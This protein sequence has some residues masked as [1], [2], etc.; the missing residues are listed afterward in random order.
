MRNASVIA[1]AL[2]LL[3]A[4]QEQRSVRRDVEISVRTPEGAPVSGAEITLEGAR[5]GATDSKG[6]LVTWFEQPASGS[7]AVQVELECPSGYEPRSTAQRI[8]LSDTRG[9][10][11]RPVTP[12][13]SLEC[14]PSQVSVAVVVRTR[15]F[16]KVPVLVQG[17]EVGDTGTDGVLH[18]A[19]V[20][21]PRS[22]IRVEVD[23]SSLPGVTPENPSRTFTMEARDSLVTF[24]PRLEA[25]P[26]PPRK[27][28]RRTKPQPRQ[29]PYRLD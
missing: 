17:Q 5:R 15:G 4:C 27:A 1:A 23:T 20:V 3:A 19:T 26:P 9:L 14:R 8:A 7:V 29:I 12:R 21:A 24:D 13:L 10:D 22:D 28:R 25:P 6:T 18:Y 11:A 2:L 16:E